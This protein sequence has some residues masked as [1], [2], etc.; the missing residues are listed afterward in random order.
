[1]EVLVAGASGF[2]G[3][4]L[5]RALDDRNTAVRAMTRAPERY[6]G[7]GK[8]VFGDI[9]DRGSLDLALAGVDAAYYLVHSLATRDFA[10]RD[11]EGA[12][13]FGAAAAASGVRQVI[14]LGG[15]GDTADDLSPHLRSRREIEGVLACEVPTTS[16][17]AGI[18]VGDGGVSWEILVQLVERL[19]LMI[20]PRWVDTRCQPVGITDAV[21][22]LCDLLG[23]D[24]A[25]GA[26]F[27]LGGADRLT[28]R[29][30]LKT[31]ATMT[32]RHK[33]I[34]PVPLLSPRLSSH[35]LRL[36]TDVDL[37]TARTL[38]DS[39]TNEVVVRDGDRLWQLLRRSPAS[40]SEVAADALRDRS[41]RLGALAVK[42]AQA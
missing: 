41:A 19:P 30:M 6:R 39:L 38:V 22:A 15:L 40:F 2:V 34:L 8:A 10:E 25:I 18:V 11:R 29:E 36:I 28:Y 35:W 3:S 31:V 33:L 24:A 16:V 32:G 9:S 26:T 21:D 20:T 12:R 5:S 14:Y 42:H 13:N 4:A 17:R 1:M 27:D 37:P 23:R 7:A